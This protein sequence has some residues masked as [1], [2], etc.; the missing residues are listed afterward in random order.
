MGIAV[1]VYLVLA[2]DGAPPDQVMRE[3]GLLGLTSMTQ[4]LGIGLLGLLLGGVFQRQLGS[5]GSVMRF[6]GFRGA[7]PVWWIAAALGAATVW[8]LPSWL[9]TRLTELLDWPDSTVNVVSE[10]LQ[11][12]VIDTW[13]LIVAVAVSAPVVEELIF[14]GYVWT[15]LERTTRPWVAMLGSTLLF[16]MYH[17][18]PVHVVSLLPTAFFLGWLRWRSGSVWPAVVAH[19]VNNA[20]AVASAQLAEPGVDPT[21]SLPWTAA[22]A[23]LA[24]T[25]LVAVVAHLS[26]D[27]GPS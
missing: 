25:A 23:G 26:A 11:G 15:L 20:L 17:L 18:D 4:I 14:R 1:G 22:L 19:F 21:E 2:G 10:A 6:L 13:P 9:A 3:P 8:T 27:R 7:S 24:F 16:A 12:P 5:D